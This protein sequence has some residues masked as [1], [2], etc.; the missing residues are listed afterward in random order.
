MDCLPKKAAIV[1]RWLLVEVG[2]YMINGVIQ[3]KD[4]SVSGTH[5]ITAKFQLE[6]MVS[7]SCCG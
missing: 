5:K 2:L 6:V 1:K 4:Q 3:V 7:T